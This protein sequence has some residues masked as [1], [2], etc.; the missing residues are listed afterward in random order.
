VSLVYPL[1]NRN[2]VNLTI[3]TFT[4]D[5]NQVA[6]RRPIFY[7]PGSLGLLY[8]EWN[9]FESQSVELCVTPAAELEITQGYQ[10]HELG[11]LAAHRLYKSELY[12]SRPPGVVLDLSPSDSD[13]LWIDMR[14]QLFPTVSDDELTPG[15]V[16]DVHQ[17][18][19][20]TL[21]SGSMAANSVFLT[22]DRDFL[23]HAPAFSERYGVS[24]LTP[25][26]AW[27]QFEPLYGLIHP[28]DIQADE[29]WQRQQSFISRLQR[30][31]P[32]RHLQDSGRLTN[33]WRARGFSARI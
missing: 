26:Q 16:A 3:P 30:E 18:F 32:K 12:K 4:L 9:Y 29:L 27:S 5:V 25:N 6:I 14:F 7:A 1:P 22:L 28:T 33:R 15:H 13:D 20:H 8:L 17:I 2:T 19:L 10:L 31:P 11:S 23:D 24:I 21:S